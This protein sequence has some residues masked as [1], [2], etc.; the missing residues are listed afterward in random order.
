M[1]TAQNYDKEL[2]TLVAEYINKNNNE[3]LDKIKALLNTQ[4]QEAITSFSAFG[5]EALINTLFS[6][7][8]PTL[9]KAH[10]EIT[11]LLLNMESIVNY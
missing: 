11:I 4:S 10:K 5:K 3:V 9:T 1:E 8:L 6:G 2:T 7:P